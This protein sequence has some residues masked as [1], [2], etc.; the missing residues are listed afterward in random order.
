MWQVAERANDVIRTV[1]LGAVHIGCRLLVLEVGLALE[2]HRAHGC[3]RVKTAA[4]AHSHVVA[5]HG[6][7]CLPPLLHALQPKRGN[8]RLRLKTSRFCDPP[9]RGCSP[10]R[11]APP[12]TLR[13]SL[14]I[15]TPCH[16]VRM[17]M[18]EQ[19]TGAGPTHTSLSS[20][21]MWI[22]SCRSLSFIVFA[23]CRI[24]TAGLSHCALWPL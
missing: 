16:E 15:P 11:P 22:S 6:S 12:G 20:P 10:S 24:S 9:A 19:T 17:R 1:R 8:E 14:D 5:A 23:R 2:A 7:H 18:H 3:P 4:Q 21:D 13:P